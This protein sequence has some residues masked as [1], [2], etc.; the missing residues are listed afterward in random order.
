L[1]PGHARPQISADGGAT[2]LTPTEAIE[3]ALAEPE[4]GWGL[5]VLG[6]LGEFIRDAGEACATDDRPGVYRRVTARGG[7]AIG[8]NHPA[9]RLIAW[10]ETS[11]TAGLWRQGAALCLPEAAA[12]IGGA[13][14]VTEL[15][16]DAEAL[17]QAGHDAVLFDMGVGFAHCRACV[18]T[19]EPALLA[20]LRAGSGQ[21]LFAA[22]NPAGAAI[23]AA[24]PHRVFLSRLARIEVYQPIPPPGGRSPD[25]PH[26]HLLPEL[27]RARR[28]HA[29]T[30]PLPDGWLSCLD[31]F[32]AHPLRDP[33]L[34]PR[35]FDAARHAG[36]QALLA[37]F[38]LPELQ[39]E[40]QRLTDAVRAGLAPA[41]FPP[42]AE[43]HGRAAA[44]VALR[45]LGWLEPGLPALPAWRAAL[46]PAQEWAQDP[47]L[48]E[49]MPGHG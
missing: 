22:G 30:R 5:G 18:R 11:P 23:L 25:G 13:A 1:T 17:H 7:I 31:L 19:A 12:N 28:A 32:P 39:R 21:P 42:A 37:A 41:T 27:L 46:E 34:A 36:F 15:G 8:L 49:A 48:A 26:T 35:P 40:K 20:A 9:L 38:G 45:Q 14:L 24:S 43:R 16:P 47:A 4:T 33:M 6:A 10:E 3:A 2:A 29:A 44:R